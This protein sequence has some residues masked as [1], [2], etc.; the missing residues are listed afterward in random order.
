M[1]DWPLLDRK[2]ASAYLLERFGLRYTRASLNTMA[3]RGSGPPFRVFRR[4]PLYSTRDLD[5]WVREQLSAASPSSKKKPI[6]EL[7][8]VAA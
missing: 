2:Q 5:Q 8:P 4:K 7:P 6:A 3:C 1:N